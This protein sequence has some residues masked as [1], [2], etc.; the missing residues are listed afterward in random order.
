MCACCAFYMQFQRSDTSVD[1]KKQCTLRVLFNLWCTLYVR[2]LKTAV[3]VWPHGQAVCGQSLIRTNVFG[4]NGAGL[5]QLSSHYAGHSRLNQIYI[6]SLHDH[7][8]CIFC[9]VQSALDALH[10]HLIVWYFSSTFC[11]PLIYLLSTFDLP[12]FH[13]SILPLFYLLPLIYLISTFPFHLCFT[14]YLSSTFLIYLY[15]TFVL[16]LFHLL[17]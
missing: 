16:P 2:G 1:S 8:A 9:M 5:L 17:F 10:Y 15:S 3:P 6:F 13:L 7:C 11:L 4:E 14:F 12:Y